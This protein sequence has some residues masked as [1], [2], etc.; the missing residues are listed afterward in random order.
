MTEMKHRF[1]K[2]FEVG[3][4]QLLVFIDTTDDNEDDY[5]A[6]HQM[7]DIGG[8]LLDMTLRG[9]EKAMRTIFDG[10][11]Q[12]QAVNFFGIETVQKM[13]HMVEARP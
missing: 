6:V 2:L 3:K 12:E 5:T 9:P 4:Y 7:T 8:A 13:I 10:Y 11:G 1:A